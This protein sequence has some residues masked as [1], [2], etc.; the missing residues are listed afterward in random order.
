MPGAGDPSHRRIPRVQPPLARRE[1]ANSSDT[2][3]QTLE[4]HGTG[5]GGGSDRI[6]N[7]RSL[8]INR[9]KMHRIREPAPP[10]KRAPPPH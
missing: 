1:C 8:S 2:A 6:V 7:G 5:G 4:A 3:V 9:H 10:K